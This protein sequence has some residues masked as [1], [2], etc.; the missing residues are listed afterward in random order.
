MAQ[1]RTRRLPLPRLIPD[2]CTL[3]VLDDDLEREWEALAVEQ[4]SSPFQRPGWFGA[5][6]AG[7]APRRALRVLTVRREGTLVAALPLGLGLLGATAPVNSETPLLAPVARDAAAT[8]AL[9][10]YLPAVAHAVDL[11]FVPVGDD[12]SL[13]VAAAGE[14]SGTVVREVVRASPYVAVDGEW[15]EHQRCAVS[16]SR[17]RSLRSADRRLSALGDLRLD[18]QDGSKNLDSL[19]REGFGL[20]AAGW[21]GRQG[22]AVM[23]QPGTARFYW[24]LARWAAGEDL[25][26][27]HFLRLDGRPIAFSFALEHRGAVFGVKTTYAEDLRSLGPGVLLTHRLVAAA[28]ER[29]DLRSFELLGESDPYKLEF[30]SGVREQVR[31][32]VYDGTVRGHAQRRLDRAVGAARSEIRRRVPTETRTRVA[33]RLSTARTLWRR[34]DS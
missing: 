32:R 26:R 34:S 30:A 6:Q 8:A 15:E 10:A 2:S 3:A 33:G 20:E 27:M 18:T 28:F 23:T 19:L 25:L 12:E 17:R 1:D 24:S 11:R 21:K 14:A 13:L 9:G 5:W 7:F 22:T 29:P 4:G 16:G 31:L